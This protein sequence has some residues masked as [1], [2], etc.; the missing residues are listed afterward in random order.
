MLF[1]CHCERGA[2]K[3][4]DFLPF[5]RHTTALF[6]RGNVQQTAKFT[7]A[8]QTSQPSKEALRHRH[9]TTNMFMDYIDIEN[10]AELLVIFS[11][12]KPVSAIDLQLHRHA[13]CKFGTTSH[14]K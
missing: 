12:C 13:P 11:T 3:F 9:F 7:P 2:R 5:N 4:C 10:D 6:A 14:L 8:S 1:T